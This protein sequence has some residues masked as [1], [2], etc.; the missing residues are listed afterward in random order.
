ML[1]LGRLQLSPLALLLSLRCEPG[2]FIIIPIPTPS[3]SSE[4]EPAS[5]MVEG[6]GTANAVPGPPI[7][8]STS[9]VISS[10]S[11]AHA[12]LATQSS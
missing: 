4:I 12:A 7:N 9:L 1:A 8:P 5:V 3:L 6:V 11:S 10:K 2:L